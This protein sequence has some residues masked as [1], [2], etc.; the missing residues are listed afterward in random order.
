[1]EEDLEPVL[2]EFLGDV[3]DHEY[4]SVAEGTKDGEAEISV[5]KRLREIFNLDRVLGPEAPLP[6]REECEGHIRSMLEE[7]KSDAG[8]SWRDILRYFMLEELDRCWKEHLRSMDVRRDGIGLRGY[9][10]KDPKLEYKREGF[11]MFQEMLF[12]IRE[13]VFRVLLRLRVQR[14]EEEEA[15]RMAVEYRHREK[16]VESLSY[17][18]GGEGVQSPRPA[19]PSPRVGRNDPCP[20]G[21]GKTKGPGN[22]GQPPAAL[23]PHDYQTAERVPQTRAHYPRDL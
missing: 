15:E 21:S 7:L 2:E 20:C 17:S 9:G 5:F 13:S 1:M 11:A 14:P 16:A 8:E 19:K 23:Y 6:G 10:Q 22:S 4:S 18:G 12:Q 3:L